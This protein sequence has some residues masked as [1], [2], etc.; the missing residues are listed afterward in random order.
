MVHFSVDDDSVYMTTKVEGKETG[1]LPFN[2]DTHNPLI[3]EHF[4]S[5]YLWDDFIDEDG[6]LQPGI[7]RADSLLLLIQNYLHAERDEKSGKE[8]LI[9]PRFHQLMVVRK[10]LKHAMTNGSGHNYL[11]QHSAGSGKSNSIAWLAHQLA[12]LCGVDGQPVFDSIVVITDRRVLN[13][14]LQDTIKEFEK[15]KGVV[16]K[17][18]R[19]TK[20]LVTA[21]KRGDKIIITT[22]QKFGFIGEM[23]KLDRRFAII[24]DEAHS[25]QTGENV[26]DL[27][28]V[29]TSDEQLRQALDKDEEEE[30]DPI[31]ME[32]EKIQKAR[33]R[34][35]HLSF[36]AFTATPKDKTLALF[37][38]KDPAVK[39]GYRPFHQYT[40][41][42]A[43]EEGFIL[44]VL[45]SY[46]T[47]KLT[48]S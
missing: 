36:F 13:K 2:R 24:V 41:R 25:S 3:P 29:L 12:N 11:V 44:D 10:L 40:M 27:K 30:I 45:Q 21:L 47:Y 28:I 6:E 34:L 19:N 31:E 37:G 26:K 5:S 14:Q 17:I 8:R 46:T 4:A 22:L 35:P 33:Q 43:I 39:E 48:S 9:F 1:F 18:D 32:L 23:V 15:I 7:L 16:T 38:T 20:Q 42:Q